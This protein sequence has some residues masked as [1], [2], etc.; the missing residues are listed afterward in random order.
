MWELSLTLQN[1][2]RVYTV[3]SETRHALESSQEM[4]RIAL[5]APEQ[6]AFGRAALALR[7][8]GDKPAPVAAEQVV[9]PIRHDDAA[10]NLWTTLNVAQ[11]HLIRGGM[12]GFRR[13]DSG[14]VIGRQNT[15]A[16]NGIDQST[17]LNRALWTLADE[18]AKLKAA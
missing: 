17:A 10:G 15:R 14:V 11:E 8:D 2:H 18:M 9:R 6:V 5:S 1:M 4:A 3:L 16:V 13:N 12:R 7:W